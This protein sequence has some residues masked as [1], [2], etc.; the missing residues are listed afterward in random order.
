[1]EGFRLSSLGLPN[2]CH[3]DPQKRGEWKGSLVEM[4]TRL[5]V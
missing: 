1:M 2:A 5:G 4:L 3:E